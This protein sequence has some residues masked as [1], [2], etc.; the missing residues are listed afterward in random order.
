MMKQK[1]MNR[2]KEINPLS[3]II[4]REIIGK[5]SAEDIERLDK[6]REEEP[7]NDLVYHNLHNAEKLRSE[8]MRYKMIN[9]ASALNQFKALIAQDRKRRIKFVINRISRV[10]AVIAFAF[11]GLFLLNEQVNFLGNRVSPPKQQICHGNVKAILT[12]GSG[13]SIALDDSKKIIS[14]DDAVIV[15]G[16]NGSLTYADKSP[17]SNRSLKF[18]DLFIPRGGEF[19]LVLSDGTKVWLNAETKFRYPVSFLGDERR[20]FL[21]GEA[22]FKVAKGS[23]PFI[24]ESQGQIVRVYGTEFNITA[25]PS[26]H[27]IYTTLIEGHVGVKAEQGDSIVDLVP[28]IQSAFNKNSLE[29]NLRHVNTEE[30][31]SWRTGMI[32]FEYQT[33]EQIMQK[34][35]RWYDFEYQ[36]S[37]IDVRNLQYKGK[38]PRYGDFNEVLDV[39]ENCGGIKFRIKGKMVTIM[40]I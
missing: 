22:Y 9:T 19:S 8:Y 38:V 14:E 34:L 11:I 17:G 26:D 36:Y 12:L 29:I 21:E 35:S 4:F 30:V 37:G 28:G 5:A 39:L 20:V 33:L 18:N 2:E 7:E 27:L 31:T 32:V 10:A 13:E 23:K 25:Y 3:A 15:K 1:N 40:G 24:V 6:W 16:D